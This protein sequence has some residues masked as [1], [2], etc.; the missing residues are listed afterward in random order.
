MIDLGFVVSAFVPLVLLW[1]F[2]TNHLRVVWRLSLGL[3]V[4]PAM[5]V[6]IW[7]LSRHLRV[8]VTS[9]LFTSSFSEMENPEAYKRSS[10]KHAKVPYLLI[11][12]RYWRSLIAVSAAW[13]LYDIIVL[14]ANRF[15]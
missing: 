10:M 11:F 13:F 9:S 6:F 2:G 5:A 15:W 14:V 4:I 8:L 12:K 7:R 1:I 3:G